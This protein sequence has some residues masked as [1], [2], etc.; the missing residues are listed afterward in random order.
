[1]S[2]L[3]SNVIEPATGTDLTLGAA[4]DALDIVGDTLQLNTWKDSG[5][6]TLFTSDGSGNVS[7]VNVALAAGGPN[8]IATQTASGAATLEFT[9]GLDSTYNK[10][11]FVFLDINPATNDVSFGFHTSTDGGS[12]YGIIKTTTFYNAH[13]YENGGTSGLAYA[14]ATFSHGNSTAVQFITQSQANEADASAAGIM[15]LFTPSST[16]Y[17]K[18]FYGRSESNH[19]I[20]AAQDGFF[21]GYINTT[22]AINAIQFKM[23]SGNFDGTIKMYGCN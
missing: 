10:Y 11:M 9:S 19:Q 16:T 8:L 23:E 21:S 12:S 6:N 5:G 2:T 1:M 17:V 20:D 15:Y 13:H 7:S 14:G 22:T 3:K 4:G 18:H